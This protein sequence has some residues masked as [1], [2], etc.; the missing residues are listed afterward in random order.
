MAKMP[1]PVEGAKVLGQRMLKEHRAANPEGRMPLM[2]HIRELRSRL[3]KA[4]LALLAGMG[5]GL[6][7]AVFDRAWHFIERPFC[8]AVIN[9]HHGCHQ[10]G[11]SLVINGIFDPFTLRIQIAFYVGLIIS[12]PVWLYQLWAFIAPGLYSREKRWAYMFVGT[13]VPLFLIG[14]TLAYLAMGRGLHFLLG[15]TPHGVFNLPTIS[16]YLGYATAMLLVFGLGFEVPLIMV[17]L[18]LAR[19]L[20]HERFRKWRRFMIFGVF[21]FAGVATPS[22]DP[23]T[24]L[25]LALPCVVLLEVAELII[26]ANDRRIARQPSPYSGLSDDEISPLDLDDSMDGSSRE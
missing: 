23:I 19:V 4:V 22:P 6:I 25:L 3:I 20:T 15:L 10:V 13:A 7:P 9:H 24:M 2:D 21:L 26:W 18:N 17:M 1:A 8:A 14:T 5:I 12:S 16:T 11:D